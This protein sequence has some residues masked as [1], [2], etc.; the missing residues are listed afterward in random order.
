MRT[1]IKLRHVLPSDPTEALNI[2]IDH[3]LFDYMDANLRVDSDNSIQSV[4]NT[5]EDAIT[6]FFKEYNRMLKVPLPI[7]AEFTKPDGSRDA[8][9]IKSFYHLMRLCSLLSNNTLKNQC[10][11]YIIQHYRKA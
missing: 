7:R 9:V 5:A 11:K 2:L 10:K 1:L 3:N 4:Y 8:K 6:A